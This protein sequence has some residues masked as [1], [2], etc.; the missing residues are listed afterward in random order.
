M[1]ND[2]GQLAFREDYRRGLDYLRKKLSKKHN[3]GD[4]VRCVFDEVKASVNFIL[5][6]PAKY[7]GVLEQNEIDALLMFRQYIRERKCLR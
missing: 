7:A 6:Q 2:Y 5:D 1:S 3:E 4:V